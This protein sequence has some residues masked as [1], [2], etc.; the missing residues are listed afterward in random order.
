MKAKKIASTLSRVVGIEGK[1]AIEYDSFKWIVGKTTGSNIEYMNDLKD[2]I[3]YAHI[4]VK[5]IL[6]K[7]NRVADKIA[8]SIPAEAYSLAKQRSN[9]GLIREMEESI[10]RNI[11]SVKDVVVLPQG[12]AAINHLVANKHIDLD[13]GNVLII[14]GGFSTLNISVVDKEGEILF[15][16]TIHDELGVRN[17][18]TRFF[19][20]E[21]KNKYDEVSS[22]DQ[23][24]KKVFL[25]EEIEAGFSTINVKTEKQRALQA[26]IPKLIGRVI[27]DVKKDNI[28]FGQ[29]A[30]VGGISYYVNAKNIETTK[31]FFIPKKDGEFLTVL[32]MRNIVGEDFDVFDIGFGDSKYLLADTKQEK[33]E[34]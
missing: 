22:N 16:E 17:L 7:E 2:L 18:L 34:K 21:L 26:F 27:R 20:E 29:F 19:R 5:H 4:F 24:L 33:E 10:L 30:F 13:N 23:M 28:S 14:D 25:E 32:G 15:N 9:G 31:K 1:D 12:V 6:T 11:P 3:N 8:I